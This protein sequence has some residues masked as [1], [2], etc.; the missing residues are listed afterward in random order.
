MNSM[1][2]FTLGEML[3][4][5]AILGTA[6]LA[7]SS[8]IPAFY[9]QNAY[10]FEATAALGNARRGLETALDR[11]RESAYGEDG[12]YPL[13]SAATSTLSFHADVD[14]DAAIERVR[15]FLS[16]TTF[17][18]SITNPTGSPPSYT[19]ASAATSTVVAYIA[20]GTSTPLFR[21]YDSSGTVLSTPVDVSE[22]TSVEVTMRVDLNP[23]RAPD[24]YTLSGNATLRNLRADSP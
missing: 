24:I 20:N 7:L 16:G 5:I 3:V 22:V 19:G 9:R 1:R 2:G 21:Y 6:G 12:A 23:N 18:E 13:L 15:Y 17:Y 4:V 14:G 10:L 8:A 11:L